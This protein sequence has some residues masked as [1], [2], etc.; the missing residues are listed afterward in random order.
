VCNP[1]GSFAASGR[2]NGA[3]ARIAQRVIQISEP[4]FV[5]SG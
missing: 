4:V 3:H 2:E 5:A 1:I